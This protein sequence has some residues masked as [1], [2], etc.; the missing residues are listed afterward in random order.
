MPERECVIEDKRDLVLKHESG[1]CDIY[2]I[3]TCKFAKHPT[4]S[5]RVEYGYAGRRNGLDM[6]LV[7]ARSAEELYAAI[8]DISKR[9]SGC[10]GVYIKPTR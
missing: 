1:L 8:V 7:R 6:Y 10:E 4:P 3:P 5:L 9:Y 2:S